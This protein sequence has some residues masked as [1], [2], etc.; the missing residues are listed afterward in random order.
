MLRRVFWKER[1]DEEKQCY[2]RV[3][4]FI[5]GIELAM[6]SALLPD[7]HRDS[8]RT[9]HVANLMPLRRFRMT[10][11]AWKLLIALLAVI[12][13]SAVASSLN[14]QDAAAPLIIEDAAASLVVELVARDP[15]TGEKLYT[16]TCYVYFGP[17][18]GDDAPSGMDIAW[19]NISVSRG[20]R[21][22]GRRC[23]AREPFVLETGNVR[24][25]KCAKE[26]R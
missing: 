24:L 19:E 9:N 23:D 16:R 10:R 14:A 17:V 2:R 8:P 3:P 11:T 1:G 22:V 15:Y 4:V 21:P 18:E 20:A 13:L 26:R 5:G 12:V 25:D 6:R 7:G